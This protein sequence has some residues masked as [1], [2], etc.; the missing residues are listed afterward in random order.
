MGFQRSYFFTSRGRAEDLSLVSGCWFRVARFAFHCERGARGLS[1]C[2]AA[3]WIVA[4][5]EVTVRARR[6]RV[7][8]KR[9]VQSRNSSLESWGDELRIEIRMKATAANA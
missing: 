2:L 1:V 9:I 6:M 3:S 4:R 8:S 5:S 7:N